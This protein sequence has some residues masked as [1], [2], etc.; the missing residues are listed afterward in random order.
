MLEY[1]LK[2][3]GQAVIALWAVITISFGLVQI[4]P[5]GPED[6]FRSLLREQGIGDDVTVSP[7]LIRDM[8]NMNPSDPIHIQYIDYLS[9]VAFRQDFGR[10]IRWRE[11]VVSVMADAL[12]WT[13]FLM[14]M[15]VI[16][17]FI[18]G[19]LLGG[20][21]AYWEGSRFDSSVT[22]VNIFTASI[23]NYVF[24][25]LL[26]GTLAF[27]FDLFPLAGRV[28]ENIPPGFNLEFMKSIVHHAT[29]PFLAMIIAGFGGPALA[30]RGNA[31]Q[32]LGADYI[33]VARLRGLSEMRIATR[34][35][36]RNAMLPL[37]TLFMIS[38]ASFFSGAVIIEEIFGYRGMG[39][40]I[41]QAFIARDIPVLMAG[42]ILLSTVTIVGV[43]IADLT[44]GLIDPRI[45]TGDTD[46]SF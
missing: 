37:Y 38:L 32:V 18:T 31:I 3:I 21:M 44:Y 34:Y 45:Q 35:V 43:L 2:R 16:V 13:I 19:I 8:T 26:L 27:Q 20:F 6:Y 4:V 15:A 30:M 40:V 14:T 10:S 17:T 22:I 46:E 7:E 36:T 33:R 29:L 41:V 28:D 42:F 9:A 5:G 25:L 39:F 24:A 23:P 11:P 12:P 1:L